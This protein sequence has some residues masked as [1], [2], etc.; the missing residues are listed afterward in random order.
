M[1]I[2]RVPVGLMEVNCYF[3]WSKKDAVVL[4]DPGADAACISTELQ[5]N[6]LAPCAVL[7]THGHFDHI[8][9]VAELKGKYGLE[10]IIGAEDEEM[11]ADPEKNASSLVG[12]KTAPFQA[13]R[14]VNNGE[15]FTVGGVEFEAYH[16]PGH[17][18]G[19]MTYRCG[20]VLFTGDTLFA[21]SVGRTDFYGG[22]FSA[23]SASLKHL[24]VLRGDYR[25]LPG[26]GPETTLGTERKINPFLGA[27]YDSLS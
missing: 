27:D 18:K 8:G 10:V 14:L 1:Q 9:A 19:S 6:G 11:L 13:E 24:A 7:L 26:H 25:V 17:T 20:D 21:G 12:V 23:L 3:V 15:V 2:Y 22:D 16:T 4:I 5:E